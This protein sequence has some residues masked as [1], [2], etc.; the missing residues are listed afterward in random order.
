[1]KKNKESVIYIY[2]TKFNSAIKNNEIMFICKKNGAR[3]HHSKQNMSASDSK[4]ET[5]HATFVF[6]SRGDPRAFI[7]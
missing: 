2:T 7:Q 4:Y 1:M 6:Q 3:D 5:Q